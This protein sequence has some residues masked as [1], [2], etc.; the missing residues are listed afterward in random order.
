MQ[1]NTGCALPFSTN[2]FLKNRLPWCAAEIGKCGALNLY[3]WNCAPFRG[4]ICAC[5]AL[6]MAAISAF[7]SGRRRLICLIWTNWLMDTKLDWKSA[8]FKSIG[9][10]TSSILSASLRNNNDELFQP[11][12]LNERKKPD[13]TKP[14]QFLTLCSP[15]W[16]I[17]WYKWKR[18][19]WFKELPLLL[20][21]LLLLLFFFCTRRLVC[22]VRWAPVFWTEDRGFESWPDQ[23]SGSLND[24]EES[25]ALLTTSANG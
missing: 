6:R 5:T 24:R 20:L 25:V 22:S 9:L 8:W 18:M 15:R 10:F 17:L 23:H 11:V 19:V 1:S 2:E 3:R 4:S 7:I 14:D 16:R 21:L 12:M 13:S